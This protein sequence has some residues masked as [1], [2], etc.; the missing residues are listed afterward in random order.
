MASDQNIFE[1][2]QADYDKAAYLMGV[3][4]VTL[5]I[6]PFLGA[7]KSLSVIGAVLAFLCSIQTWRKGQRR[8]R[9]ILVEHAAIAAVKAILP[10]N[11]TLQTDV[12]AGRVGNIDMLVSVGEKTQIVVEIKSYDGIRENAYGFL[13]KRSG[14]RIFKNIVAQVWNQCG[15]VG[16]KSP[17]IWVPTAIEQHSFK[18][19]KGIVVVNGNAQML[20]NALY[21]VDENVKRSFEIKFDGIPPQWLREDVKNHGFR[22]D[23]MV[24]RGWGSKLEMQSLAKAVL[25]EGGMIRCS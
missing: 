8:E 15:A 23:G 13:V 16:S 18:S 21:W 20:L 5:V 2:W 6:S 9:G 25:A 22:F 10:P 4:A 17:V 11:W 19:Q 1:P 3:A 14:A 7:F 24:W 12:S